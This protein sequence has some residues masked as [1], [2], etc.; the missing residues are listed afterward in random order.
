[1][2]ITNVNNDLDI[3]KLPVEFLVSLNSAELFSAIFEFKIRASV[4][5]L[6]NMHFQIELCNNTCIII[7]HFHCLCIEAFILFKQFA[8]QRH[9]LYRINF[10]MQEDDYSWIIIRKQ[11]SVCLCFAIIINKSQGQFFSVID[12][13]IQHQCFLHDQLYMALSQII[14]IEYLYLLKDFNV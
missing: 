5:L 13:N 10:I 8:N 3:H 14:D 7:T 2:N 12:L 9:I 11:F 1:M 4:M 6:W